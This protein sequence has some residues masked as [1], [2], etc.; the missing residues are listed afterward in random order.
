VSDK[1][2]YGSGGLFNAGCDCQVRVEACVTALIVE[3]AVNYVVNTGNKALSLLSR[4]KLLSVGDTPCCEV[5]FQR[6]GQ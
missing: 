1:V 5:E 3:F 6:H 4:G 2:R